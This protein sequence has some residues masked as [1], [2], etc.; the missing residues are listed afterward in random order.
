VLVPPNLYV[1]NTYTHYIAGFAAPCGGADGMW[2]FALPVLCGF[3]K[4]FLMGGWMDIY[5]ISKQY[6][7]IAVIVFGL[8]VCV[9]GVWAVSRAVRII[10]TVYTLRLIKN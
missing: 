6:K 8:C 1:H 10:Y 3:V 7:L 4:I 5:I 9:P 2:L